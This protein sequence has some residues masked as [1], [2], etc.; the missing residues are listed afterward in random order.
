MQG[1]GLPVTTIQRNTTEAM[2]VL[3]QSISRSANSNGTA[4]PQADLHL[5]DA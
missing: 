1:T 3:V 4:A 5:P 2:R